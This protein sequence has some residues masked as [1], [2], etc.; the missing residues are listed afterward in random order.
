MKK[1]PF[2]SFFL[3]SCLDILNVKENR[4][5]IDSMV[6]ANLNHERRTSSIA[7]S[8]DDEA[9]NRQIQTR[10]VSFSYFSFGFILILTRESK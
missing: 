2:F 1:V 6:T 9:N 10:L 8:E 4:F 5:F 3:S 7:E